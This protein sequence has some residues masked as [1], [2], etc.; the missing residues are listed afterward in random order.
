MQSSTK[1]LPRRSWG[2]VTGQEVQ[3]PSC[4]VIEKY[5]TLQVTAGSTKMKNERT[6]NE[7]I[8]D[9]NAKEWEQRQAWAKVLAEPAKR[10]ERKSVKQGFF[11][12][13]FKVA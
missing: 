9:Y 2:E 4:S 3:L 5:A 12:Q 13:F 8:A 6:A 1:G 7:A 10:T 11:S